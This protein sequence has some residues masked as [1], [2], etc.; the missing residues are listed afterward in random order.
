MGRVLTE[1]ITAYTSHLYERIEAFLIPSVLIK[2]WTMS[3]ADNLLSLL[4]E[5]HSKLQA[6]LTSTQK[7]AAL[8]SEQKQAL[9]IDLAEAQRAREQA[10]AEVHSGLF[11][12][13]CPL[14]LSCKCSRQVFLLH[15][16]QCMWQSGLQCI[17]LLCC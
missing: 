8:L 5:A 4:Q 15:I 17:P 1:S 16:E 3:P 12:C 9:Q 13:S 7:H 2:S 6:E 11:A 14:W 10:L